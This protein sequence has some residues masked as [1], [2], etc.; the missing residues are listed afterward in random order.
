MGKGP[1]ESDASDK[2]QLIAQAQAEEKEVP[3]NIAKLLKKERISEQGQG[4]PLN[5]DEKATLQSWRMFPDP[6]DAHYFELYKKDF[7]SRDGREVYLSSYFSGDGQYHSKT[8]RDGKYHGL[9]FEEK[10]DLESA[11]EISNRG[12]I[13]IPNQNFPGSIKHYRDLYVRDFL[14]RDGKHPKLNHQEQLELRGLLD[15]LRA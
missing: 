5:L 6:K 1:M 15:W 12:G 10:A 14:S 4:A 9:S 2:P 13:R 7:L 3:G 8:S 11:V